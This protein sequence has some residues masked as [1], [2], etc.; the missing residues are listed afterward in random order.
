LTYCTIFFTFNG[1]S[2]ESCN[3]LSSKNSI[4][5]SDAGL[6]RENETNQSTPTHSSIVFE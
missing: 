1:F 3:I 2:F 4:A 6:V 5:F